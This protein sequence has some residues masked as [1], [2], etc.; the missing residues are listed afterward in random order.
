MKPA[1][2]ETFYDV[3]I[4][5]EPAETQIAQESLEPRNNSRF[6]IAARAG[7][8]IPVPWIEQAAFAASVDFGYALLPF[9]W[10]EAELGFERSTA[11]DLS[12]SF[13][14]PFGRLLTTAEFHQWSLPILLGARVSLAD[15]WFKQQPK[16]ELS[17]ALQ[18]GLVYEHATFEADTPSGP[19]VN[20]KESGLAPM[21][22]ARVEGGW[23]V[24]PGAIVVSAAW[25]QDLMWDESDTAKRESTGLN[26]EAGWRHFF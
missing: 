10:L 13:D 18:V 2:V 11:N 26:L 20:D 19:F 3:D 24:G 9:L 5:R 21:V 12:Q 1:Y 8:M 25:R 23:R 14:L 17:A 16:L 7:T 15:L 6:S 4:W 22:S